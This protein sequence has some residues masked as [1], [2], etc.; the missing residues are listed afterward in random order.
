[1][2]I[3]QVVLSVW[4]TSVCNWKSSLSRNNSWKALQDNPE[5]VKENI[6]LLLS[7]LFL[8]KCQTVIH[9]STDKAAIFGNEFN[10]LFSTSGYYCVDIVR[11][12]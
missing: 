7:K 9:M 11:K 1:M 2:N 12:F 8:K 3:F 5:I 10:L 4:Q 6:P